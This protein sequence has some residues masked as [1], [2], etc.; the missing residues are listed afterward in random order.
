MRADHTL[1]RHIQIQR[2][3][4]GRSRKDYTLCCEYANIKYVLLPHTHTRTRTKQSLRCETAS[5]LDNSSAA[6]TATNV[7]YHYQCLPLLCHNLPTVAV[8]SGYSKRL[9]PIPFLC[10][11]CIQKT[12]F[13][14]LTDRSF[15]H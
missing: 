15:M 1:H 14:M 8:I 12:N 2:E 7:C 5:R 9:R 3:R 4:G 10:L 6:A 13:C 11:K